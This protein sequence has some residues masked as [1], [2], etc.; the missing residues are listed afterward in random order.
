MEIRLTTALIPK[1]HLLT[2][3]RFGSGVVLLTILIGVVGCAHDAPTPSNR[4]TAIRH[5]LLPDAETAG[6][7]A[8]L[9]RNVLSDS[10]I[11]V[12]LSTSN[13]LNHVLSSDRAKQIANRKAAARLALNGKGKGR[14]GRN[15]FGKGGVIDER[16]A[17]ALADYDPVGSFAGVRNG[18]SWDSVR[19]GM[20]LTG[21]Q[22]A[23]LTAHVERLKQNP[24]SV[25]FLMRKAEPYLS[26]LY[27]ETKRYGLPTEVLL[28][29]MVE[30]AFETTA[31]SPKQAAG[32]WQF[33][34]STGQRFGLTVSDTY[35]ERYDVHP[36]TQAA[37]RYLKY[38]NAIFDGDWLLAFAGY[39]AGEGAVQR[40]IAANKQAGGQGTFWE[41][42]L[43]TETQ[44]YV[45]K[46]LALAKVISHPEGTGVRSISSG[47]GAQLAR[48]EL[49]GD[50]RISDVITKSGMS[51]EDFYRLNP[52]LKGGASLPLQPRNIMMPLRSAEML[53][54]RN[55]KGIKVFLPKKLLTSE[56][57]SNKSHT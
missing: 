47:V 4:S 10:D 5:R 33:I 41:L 42:N 49:E 24:G 3:S 43:P 35:D 56:L 48:I 2:S 20:V 23:N 38:L 1:G 17:V 44:A 6:S 32:I 31:I 11:S 19:S 7:L 13:M 28:V 55:V 45:V 53:M 36:A 46:I 54:N 30:S 16:D 26:Y 12:A 51:A 40:A 22:H 37:L 52:A 27:S 9:D 15:L 39:N 14:S 50:V 29:P 25:E 57:P 8:D 18:D 21:I 34:P